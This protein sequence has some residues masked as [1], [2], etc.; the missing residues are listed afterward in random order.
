MKN[1]TEETPED[2][3]DR[4]KNKKMTRKEALKKSGYIALSASTMLMLLS[5]PQKAQAMSTA[6]PA[7][8]PQ[9]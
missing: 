3:L 7:P 5:N 9:F 6:P 2:S 8:L 1:K 4:L